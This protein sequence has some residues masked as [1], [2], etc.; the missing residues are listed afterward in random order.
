MGLGSLYDVTRYLGLTGPFVADIHM[1]VT[2]GRRVLAQK[3]RFPAYVRM[4]AAPAFSSLVSE[5]ATKM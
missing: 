1:V 3:H 5:K 4:T 2:I